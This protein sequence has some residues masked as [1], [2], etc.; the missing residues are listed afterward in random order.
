T[1]AT[2]AQQKLFG[3]ILCVL[4]GFV[5]NHDLGIVLGSRTAVKIT[6]YDGR[7]PDILFVRKDRLGILERLN[8]SAA[9]DLV[10]E[11][12]SP[13]DRPSDKMELESDYRSI[14]VPEIIFVDVARR[15]VQ[16]FRKQG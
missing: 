12:I 11:L 8:L 6:N 5:E 1:P 15:R 2:I 14:G 16:A 10:I 3:W 9:P 7:L 4:G 13:G